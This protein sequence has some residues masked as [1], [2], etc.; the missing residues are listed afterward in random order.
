MHA[1]M[2]WP[3]S[4]R[5]R[6]LLLV[7]FSALSVSEPRLSMVACFLTLVAVVSRAASG[8]GQ[9]SRWAVWGS[10]TL[11]GLLALAGFFRFVMVE[12]IP[13]VIAGGRAA[14]EKHAVAYLRT[15]VAAQDY[16]RRGAHIDPDGDG[17]GSAA[18]LGE[19]A[20]RVALR[21]GQAPAQYPLS[22]SADE[23]LAGHGF[24]AS[25]AYIF[26][27]CLPAAEGWVNVDN[28]DTSVDGLT[29]DDERAER[30]YLVYGWPRT[31]SPGAPTQLYVADA[32]E[33]IWVMDPQDPQQ[34]PAYVG[35]SSP[36]PCSLLVQD[37]R[38]APWKGKTAR[39]ELPGDRR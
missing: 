35:E 7:I 2:F 22:V 37:R 10:I 9:T 27:V 5:V 19:L 36:P 8:A 28:A 26:R 20:G 34:K 30:E 21:M 25:G 6:L 1:A 11:S 39:P 12:A 33:R 16:M 31:A 23:W 14:A 4:L 38:F 13:G 3:P 17:V 15:I 24:V 18:S 29:V 32:Y